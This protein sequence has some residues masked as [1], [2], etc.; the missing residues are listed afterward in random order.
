MADR[1]EGVTEL[2]KV[3]EKLAKSLP[4]E[5]V[6]PVLLEASQM[7]VEAG[8]PVTPYDPSRE[9]GTHLRDAWVAKL[10]PRRGSKA[11]PAIAAMNYKKA[12][13]AHLVEFGTVNMSPRPYFRPT[14]DRM[15]GQVQEKLINALK[16][17]IVKKV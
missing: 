12:P 16:A 11:A 9:K 15:H 4:P 13:H 8:R 6:E 5:Q 3:F 7:I 17:L 10:M 14:W 2:N 1:L